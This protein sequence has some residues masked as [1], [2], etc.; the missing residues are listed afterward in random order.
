MATVS[1]PVKWQPPATRSISTEVSGKTARY[2]RVIA[3]NIGTLPDWHSSAGEAAW[4]FA[5]EIQIMFTFEQGNIFSW[6]IW[7]FNIPLMLV[8]ILVFFLNMRDTHRVLAAEKRRELAAVEGNIL[9]ACRTLMKRLAANES[10]GTLAA[11]INALVAYEQRLQTAR[12]WP[13]NTA[14]L[15]TLLF[16]FV[17]PGGAVLAQFAVQSLLE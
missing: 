11:E 10:T 6:Q 17:I 2:V 15:R 5:D 4:L 14:M 8:P 3:K 13:Y 9:R 12:T 7:V 1:D 16:S